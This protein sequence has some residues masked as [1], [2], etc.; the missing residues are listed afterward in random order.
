MKALASL[1]LVAVVAYAADAPPEM[2]K[3]VKE[4]EWLK[5]LA[6]DWTERCC[7]RSSV[8]CWPL[9]SLLL[10]LS[11]VTSDLAAAAQSIRAR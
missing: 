6:G 1:F 7:R 5:Q 11:S 2:P 4:H 9:L 10:T 3:P 8:S